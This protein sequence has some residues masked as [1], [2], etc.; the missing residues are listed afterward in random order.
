MLLVVSGTKTETRKGR[1]MTLETGITKLIQIGLL[2]ESAPVPIQLRLVPRQWF[3]DLSRHR[4][5]AFRFLASEQFENAFA[6][7][8]GLTLADTHRVSPFPG[9]VSLVNPAF[10]AIRVRPINEWTEIA[11]WIIT[12]SD[13]PYIPFNFRATRSAWEQVRG[14]H[15]SAVAIWEAVCELEAEWHREKES[16][17]L[18][19]AE[20]MRKQEEQAEHRMVWRHRELEASRVLA[21][22][23]TPVRE[24]RLKEMSSMSP[25]ERLAI[26]ARDE[27]YKIGYYP[28][29]FALVSEDDLKVLDRA[30]V[31][32][33]REKL[34]DRR[35]GPWK[36]L[37][38]LLNQ[39]HPRDNNEPLGPPS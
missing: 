28:L 8:R 35:K 37:L 36:E 16:R 29:E 2:T 3:H 21:A 39:V 30:L 27:L 1:R 14:S 38:T 24:H 32:Q 26:I 4:Y 11:D 13:N 12:N 7:M 9:S 20:R 5:E 10:H 17:A 33:L 23:H 18:A 15:S 34:A 6:F 25:A 31:H 19:H 22:A